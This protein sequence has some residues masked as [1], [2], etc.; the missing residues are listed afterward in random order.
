MLERNT[1][2]VGSDGFEFRRQS[3]LKSLA[4][5]DFTFETSIEKFEISGTEPMGSSRRVIFQLDDRLYKFT[6]GSLDVYNERGTFDDIIKYGNT[7]GELLALSADSLAAFVGKRVYP[8]IALDCPADSP[9]M[10]RIKICAK[11]KNYNDLYTVTRVTPIYTLK[12]SGD[13]CKIVA[14][15]PNLALNGNGVVNVKCKL[16][17]PVTGWS[18]WLDF[19][20]AK[21]QL[22]TAAQIQIR[23]I[24]TTM[25]GSDLAKVNAVDITYTTDSEQ[26]SGE[27]MEIVTLPQEFYSDLETCYALIKTGELVDCELKAYASFGAPT[28]RRDNVTLGTATG[29]LQTVQLIYNGELDTGVI[30]E[31]IHLTAGDKVIQQFDFDTQ[32]STLTFTGE[33][34][35]TIVAS[36]ER[37]DEESWIELQQNF[38]LDDEGTVSTRFIGRLENTTGK[39]VSAVKFRFIRKSGSVENELLSVGTGKEQAFV[40]PHHAKAESIQCGG[41]WRYDEDTQILKVVAAIGE[42]ISVSYSWEG[43]FPEVK[44]YIAGWLAAV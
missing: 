23:Y 2:Q 14:V 38:S 3:L 17:H 10:P 16:C 32:F 21:N 11:V 33:S 5:L 24:V 43:A 39:S 41:S 25:D 19:I 40:L 37:C 27:A 7:V 6:N 30:P 44:N 31:S 8:W 13:A 26:L 35:A 29:E 12:R 20:D 34:G 22:A 28:I 18:D 4:P 15:Q 42:N 1:M 9:V 36:Y